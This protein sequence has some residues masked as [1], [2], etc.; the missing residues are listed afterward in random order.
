M[1]TAD[2]W[3]LCS[4]VNRP[5]AVPVTQQLHHCNALYWL[6]LK[7]ALPSGCKPGSMATYPQLK[8]REGDRLEGRNGREEEGD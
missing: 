6:K 1:K 4:R 5:D 3:D 8:F 2:L 7:L